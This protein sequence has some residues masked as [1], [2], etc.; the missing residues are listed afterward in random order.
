MVPTSLRQGIECTRGRRRRTVR[1]LGSALG[2]STRRTKRADLEASLA[3]RPEGVPPVLL[4]H[5]PDRFPHAVRKN[6]E[7]VLSRRFGAA[8]V[9]ALVKLRS[10]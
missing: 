4:A 5:D 8:P 6:V 3:D 9:V 10:V 7:V 1:E 2:R